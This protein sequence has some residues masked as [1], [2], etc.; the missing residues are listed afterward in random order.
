MSHDEWET[1]TR[2]AVLVLVPWLCLASAGPGC[3]PAGQTSSG[4][5]GTRDRLNKMRALRGTG[6]PRQY[7]QRPA[8]RAPQKSK[9]R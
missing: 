7:A 8:I 2:R 5:A 3:A 1:M 6:D 4:A 9:P